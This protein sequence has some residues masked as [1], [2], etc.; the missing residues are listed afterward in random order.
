MILTVHNMV[1]NKSH[2]SGR[3]HVSPLMALGVAPGSSWFIGI[4]P[5]GYPPMAC[6]EAYSPAMWDD[7]PNGELETAPLLFWSAQAKDSQDGNPLP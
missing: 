2:A 4:V 1:L 7:P 5:W 3:F 6:N